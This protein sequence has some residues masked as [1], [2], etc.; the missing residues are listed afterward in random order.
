MAL[1]TM[2]GLTIV[3]VTALVQ[4]RHPQN[5]PVFCGQ[6]KKFFSNLLE[7]DAFFKGKHCNN[8]L[9]ML[10]MLKEYFITIK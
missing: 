5:M 1:P 8:T 6:E 4:N 3:S 9:V 7:N 10:T 2:G